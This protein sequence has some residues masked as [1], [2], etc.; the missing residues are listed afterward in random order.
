[1][2]IMFGNVSMNELEKVKKELDEALM[3]ELEKFKKELEEA[4]ENVNAKL[5]ESDKKSYW[6]ISC[7]GKVLCFSKN[8][9]SNYDFKKETGNYFKTEKEAEEYLEDLKVKTKIKDIAKELN[10][11]KEIDWND[12]DQTKYCLIYDYYSLPSIKCKREWIFKPEGTICCLDENFADECIN[13]IGR[14]KLE[15]YLRRN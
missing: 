14:E 13:R 1:M 12:E 15:K 10:G 9:D 4:L 6:A 11:Y 7:S 5:E 3:N 8:K 2:G